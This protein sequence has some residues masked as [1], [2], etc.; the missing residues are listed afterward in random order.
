MRKSTVNQLFLLGTLLFMLTSAPLWAKTTTY[1][2]R[3]ILHSLH[4]AILSS[5]LAA[6]IT[7]LPFKEG[8]RFHKGDVLIQFDCKLP[9]AQLAAA[10]EE[11]AIKR[12]TWAINKELNRFKSV[13]R[14]ELLKSEAEYNQAVAQAKTLR[15][16]VNYCQIKAPFDGIVQQTMISRYEAV[17]AGQGLIDII[18]P[19]ALQITFIVPSHWLNWLKVGTPFIFTIDET[20]VSIKGKVQ[21]LSPL[22]DAVSQTI[23]VFGQLQ[24]RPSNG[25]L[26][27]GMS[28]HAQFHLVQEE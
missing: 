23:H 5:E 22:V 6:Q 15:I 20:K 7:E 11:I 13:G 1:Q 3:G 9:K 16:R 8:M 2:A 27:P 18:D 26:Y 12:N 19:R 14:Y 28:G 4:H 17:A 10:S 21:Y 25:T 24:N